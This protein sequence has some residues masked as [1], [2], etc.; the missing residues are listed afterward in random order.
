VLEK[1]N[2]DEVLRIVGDALKARTLRFSDHALQRMEERDIKL[3][4]VEQTIKYGQR[5][6]G[7]DEFDQKYNYWRYVIRNK[8]VEDRDLAISVDIEDSPN[9]VIVT[10][11]QIDP[12]TARK[13]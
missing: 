13:L 10:V 8:N 1:I 9:A 6:P 11:M 4:E 3:F 12:A 7:L 2:D 5:E